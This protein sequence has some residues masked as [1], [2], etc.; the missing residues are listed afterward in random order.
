MQ[1][2]ATHCSIS[3]SKT[4]RKNFALVPSEQLNFHSVSPENDR[5]FTPPPKATKKGKRRS[6]PQDFIHSSFRL[7]VGPDVEGSVPA[8]WDHI[9]AL[10]CTM[11]SPDPPGAFKN[12]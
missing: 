4:S 11:L 5:I 1:S 9:E 6:D 8:A 12:Y 2:S 3:N 7:L 10:V